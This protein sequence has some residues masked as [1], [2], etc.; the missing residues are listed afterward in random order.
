MIA[1]AKGA[2]NNT[3]GFELVN[4][5]FIVAFDLHIKFVIKIS[6]GKK[7]YTKGGYL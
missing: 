7:Y 1:K 5:F 4:S 6:T 2:N 3:N